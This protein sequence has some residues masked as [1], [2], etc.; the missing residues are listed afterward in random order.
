M[1]IVFTEDSRIVSLSGRK[2]YADADSPPGAL[3][4]IWTVGE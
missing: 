4:R 3:I 2:V 1:G